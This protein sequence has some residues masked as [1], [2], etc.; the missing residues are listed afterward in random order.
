MR[1]QPHYEPTPIQIAKACQ[2][3]R[4]SWS[5]EERQRRL[6]GSG[7]SRLASRWYPPCIDA[8]V[9]GG[10]VQRKFADLTP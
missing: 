4:D 5:P 1:I 10:R 2:E 9:S 8:S 6:V 3:I 7:I